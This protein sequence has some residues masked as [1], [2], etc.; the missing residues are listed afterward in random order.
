VRYRNLRKG[1]TAPLLSRLAWPGCELG[2]GNHDAGDGQYSDRIEQRDITSD[3][4]SQLP[5]EKVS[6]NGSGAVRGEDELVIRS[7]VLGATKC[8]GTRGCDC[9]PAS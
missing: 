7:V 2:Q 8:S 9:K 5:S 4:I 3:E 1:G 6:Y